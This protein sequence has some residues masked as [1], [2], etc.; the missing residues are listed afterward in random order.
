MLSMAAMITSF[1]SLPHAERKCRLR[2]AALPI[3]RIGTV[4]R[5]RAGEI[6]WNGQLLEP[7]GFDHFE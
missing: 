2:S 1:S 4:G 7:K 3:T 5:G 6:V